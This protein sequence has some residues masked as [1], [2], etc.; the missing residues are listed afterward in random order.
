MGVIIGLAVT[1]GRLD[2]IQPVQLAR[3]QFDRV[4]TDVLLDPVRSGV[5]RGPCSGQGWI[6]SPAVPAAT[7]ASSRCCQR[8]GG[9]PWCRR[10]A[11]AKA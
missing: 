5:F 1:H 11:V 10:N 6:T 8:R 9:S 3:A 7:A 4:G 2:V